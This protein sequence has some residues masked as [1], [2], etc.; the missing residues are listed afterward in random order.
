MNRYITKNLW[1]SS[2]KNYLDF[3]EYESIK[4]VD[5]KNKI[6]KNVYYINCTMLKDIGDIKKGM[7]VPYI[8]INY[9][10]FGFNEN[11]DLIFDENAIDTRTGQVNLKKLI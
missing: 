1:M 8:A 5:L 2:Q 10:I 11:N 9:N 6:E 7:K 4:Y 3:F